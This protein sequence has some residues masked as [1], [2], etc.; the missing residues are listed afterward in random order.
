MLKLKSSCNKTPTNTQLPYRVSRNTLCNPFIRLHTD[1]VEITRSGSDDV[2]SPTRWSQWLPPGAVPARQHG[3]TGSHSPVNTENQDQLRAREQWPV[4]EISQN[5]ENNHP[6]CKRHQ[7]REGTRHHQNSSIIKLRQHNNEDFPSGGA[8]T[9]I[10]IVDGAVTVVAFA[11]RLKTHWNII[12]PLDNTTFEAELENVG[13]HEHEQQTRR[14]HLIPSPLQT[15]N[16]ENGIYC[17]S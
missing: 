9:L 1:D 7:V 15:A 5:T 10:F 17:C 14:Q 2:R 6:V 3:A 13:G 8:T 11:K 16:K 12:V 4:T